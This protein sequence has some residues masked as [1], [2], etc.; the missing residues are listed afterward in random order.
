M[1]ISTRCWSGCATLIWSRC[2]TNSDWRFESTENLRSGSSDLSEA[3]CNNG[4]FQWC[5]MRSQPTALFAPADIESGA[6]PTKSSMAQCRFA[7]SICGDGRI[8]DGLPSASMT[9]PS[10]CHFAQRSAGR[11]APG[12]PLMQAPVPRAVDFSEPAIFDGAGGGNRTHTPCG[13]GF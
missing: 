8:P 1:R 12:D 6:L 3:Q 10:D 7:P 4:G 11:A 13:T 5:Q 9:M 2:L